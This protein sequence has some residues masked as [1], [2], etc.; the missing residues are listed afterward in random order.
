MT[1]ASPKT[2]PID[3]AAY[4]CGA[5]LVEEELSLVLYD[6]R[7]QPAQG[8]RR[9]ADMARGMIVEAAVHLAEF[10][11][12]HAVA[13]LFYE[14]LLNIAAQRLQRA[15]APQSPAKGDTP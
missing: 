6:V 9:A 5:L 2:R 1:G 3:Q 11:G 4:D 15:A 8:E 14:A 13:T 12:P 10:E 7:G